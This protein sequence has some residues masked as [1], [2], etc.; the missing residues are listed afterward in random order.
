MPPPVEL[1]TAAT[2]DTIAFTLA[3]RSAP[4]V[5]PRED[6][7]GTPSKSGAVRAGG[8]LRRV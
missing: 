1:D 3:R 5:E 6:A 2:G 4:P 8:R 7:S